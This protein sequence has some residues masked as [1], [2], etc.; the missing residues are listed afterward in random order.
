[1]IRKG[2]IS[3]VVVGFF[4][5][6]GSVFHSSAIEP[7]W[8]YKIDNIAHFAMSENGEY[9]I[10]A[11]EKKPSCKGQFYIFDR[12]GTTVNHGCIKNEITAVDIA[13]NGAFFIGAQ[14]SYCLSPALEEIPEDT[15]MESV[16]E[17]VTISR[18]GEFVVAGTDKEIF[19][20]DRQGEKSTKDIDNPIKFTA[21]SGSG[22]RAVAATSDTLFLYRGS[23]NTWEELPPK[24]T[25]TALAISGDGSTIA[26][27]MTTGLVWILDSQLEKQGTWKNEEDVT[28]I[29]ITSNGSYLVCGTQDGKLFYL[30]SS[31]TQVWSY[32]EEPPK[33][34]KEPPEA[35][36]EPP[37]EKVVREV[38]VSFDGSSVAALIENVT[39]SE[40]SIMLFYSST[41][42]ISNN[43][44]YKT[45]RELKY[46]ET[47]Q[48]MQLSK[49]GEILS[50]SL[51]EELTFLELYQRD[52]TL[53]YEH[54]FPSKRSTP[55]TDYLSME[56]LYK[57]DPQ[58]VI[59]ADINGDGQNE[60]I[61]SFPKGIALLKPKEKKEEKEDKEKNVIE[62]WRKSFMFDL[63]IAAMDLTFDFKPEVI[64][65][66]KDN[67]MRFKVFDGNGRE[68]AS[69]DFYS[70]WYP[71]G[72]PPEDQTIRMHALW[73]GDIDNDGCI[74]VVCKVSAGYL[75]KPRGIF[76]F[77]YP[78]FE[79]E[80][81]YPCA[82]YVE[83]VNI[84]DINNDGNLEVIW[85]SNAPCN[86][87]IIEN[88]KT[89]DCHAY[90]SAINLQGE[91]L[92]TK[93]IGS[94]Y[95]RVYTAVADLDNDG[96]DEVVCGGWSKEDN[97][98]KLFALDAQEG[99]IDG[100]GPDL[101]H[102]VFLKGV[103]D[104]DS[105]G[106]MEIIVSDTKGALT[107]Y[108]YRFQLLRKS[109]ISVLP[110]STIVINDIDGDE[111]KE[112]IAVTTDGTIV[113]LNSLLEKEWGVSFPDSSC[114]VVENLS[115]C[116][117]NLL[118]LADNLYLY[119]YR[120]QSKQPCALPPES[121]IDRHINDGDSYFKIGKYLKAVEEY[122]LAI[123]KLQQAGDD[124]R[125]SEVTEKRTKAFDHYNEKLLDADHLFEEG[126]DSFESENFQEAGEKFLE[127]KDIY[128]SVDK[129]DKVRK[130]D[131][132]L[133]EVAD[134]LFKEGMNFLEL[135]EFIKAKEIF[136]EAK[137]IY[138]SVDK[139]DEVQ[140]ID[141]ILSEI[142]LPLQAQ[143]YIEEGK[144]EES[145]KNYKEAIK[146]YEKALK[147]Y[148]ELGRDEK[149]EEVQTMIED[150]K[151]SLIT[152]ISTVIIKIA[153]A[154]GFVV[155]S[156]LY[157]RREE[158]KGKDKRANTLFYVATI[159][160]LFGVLM[161]ALASISLPL[162]Y[163]KYIL[164]IS[165]CILFFMILH[166]YWG[167]S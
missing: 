85:G 93:E 120:D 20:F 70:Q 47:I 108:D 149:I 111:Q 95:K 60:I 87:R 138:N 154:V 21:I 109:I 65:T 130:I 15:K 39:L 114:A 43:E 139:D 134:Q 26:C 116:K 150:A 56:W 50:F 165:I 157:F 148:E 4:L 161:V 5:M 110:E 136:L 86:G 164:T 53:T 153:F 123:K 74:E 76:V 133:P 57:V 104:L 13:D 125:L 158:Y 40:S 63:E 137:K 37:E 44:K 98:G 84:V 75:L 113:I 49:F 48:H 71:D 112:I 72:P 128:N 142:E 100:E 88:T 152:Y 107:V 96:T 29:A 156:F 141:D 33:A 126:M 19:I 61:C 23:S 10:V 58:S 166:A 135:E 28:S 89:D 78:S 9:L 146:Y 25:I 83:T 101:D 91:M 124:K 14:N 18:N 38:A 80:L 162:G 73:S 82:P 22:D 90:V 94:G 121:E 132:L 32:P 2:F 106:Y 3:V 17:S 102:S 117:N 81:Y 131:E 115:W 118:I 1:M 45:L 52:H 103:S 30:D 143:E 99:Y 59:A 97:W 27:G 119:S 79:K 122:D 42:D 6:V 31:G 16:F 147:N 127:A 12:Y 46:S 66:S 155:I 7:M 24:G 67:Y 92:W 140:K 35:S 62:L 151:D 167:R 54:M 105:D 68:L 144:K 160:S 8:S 159:I 11:S 163:A 55:G 36:K 34:S 145:K 51:H 77:E 64:V 41:K 129:D 69:H